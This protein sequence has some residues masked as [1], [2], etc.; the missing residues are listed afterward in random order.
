LEDQ[1]PTEFGLTS[2]TSDS[3]QQRL[4]KLFAILSLFAGY[5]NFFEK[6]SSSFCKEKR[7]NVTKG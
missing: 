1:N 6:E 7:K 4:K 5:C 3:I 2:V